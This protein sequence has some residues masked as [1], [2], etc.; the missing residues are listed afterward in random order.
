MKLA[1]SVFPQ[2]CLSSVLEL[3]VITPECIPEYT[4]QAVSFS[5]L[6]AGSRIPA[7]QRAAGR[8]A[9]A[10][11]FL[12]LSYSEVAILSSL[13]KTLFLILFISSGSPFLSFFLALPPISSSLSPPYIYCLLTSP[14]K[15]L[16]I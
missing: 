5:L 1:P 6:V 15:L 10:F 12:P 3:P 4:H 7:G 9:T 14:G 11:L 16:P 13:F 8:K 2:C